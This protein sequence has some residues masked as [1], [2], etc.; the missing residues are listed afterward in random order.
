MVMNSLPEIIHSYNKYAPQKKYFETFVRNAIK[1]YKVQASGF[2]I[3]DQDL[4]PSPVLSVECNLAGRFSLV[5][6][7]VYDEKSVYEANRKTELKVGLTYK[8]DDV[9]FYRLKRDYAYEN[10]CVASLLS[11]GLVNREGALFY[12]LQRNKNDDGRGYA[13]I[14]WL[15]DNH[16]LMKKNGFSVV[17]CSSCIFTSLDIYMP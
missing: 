14:N 8:D 9:S 13:I 12:P 10:A 11:M 17:L 16:R 7:F 5:L 1:K 6:K 3:I 15:N 4:K 2:T